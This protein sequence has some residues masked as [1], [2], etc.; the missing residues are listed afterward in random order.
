MMP[1]VYLLHNIISPHLL[2]HGQNNIPGSLARNDASGLH[3]LH[4][5]QSCLKIAYAAVHLDFGSVGPLIGV[6]TLLLHLI[7][8]QYEV[9]Q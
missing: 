3:L 5:A 4:S 2:C 9:D 6:Q 7:P 8:L 1:S